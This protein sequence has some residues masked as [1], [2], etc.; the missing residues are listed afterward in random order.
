MPRHHLA[1]LLF[2]LAALNTPLG[3]T[4]AGRESVTLN[5]ANADI[6]TVVRA[7]GE[8]TGHN[9]L[10]DP[11]I[12]GTVNIISSQ[13]VSRALAYQILLSSLRLQGFSAVEG[14][15]VV[16]IVPESDAKLHARVATRGGQG[17]ERLIT[18]VFTLKNSN[19]AQLLPVIRPIVSPNNALSAFAQANALVVTDYADNLRRIESIVASLEGVADSQTA[20][21]PLLYASASELATTLGKLLQDAGSEGSR[22]IINADSRANV[23]LVRADLPGRLNQVRQLVQMLDQPSQAGANVRVVYLKNADAARVAQTL[24]ALL[25]S[26]AAPLAETRKSSLPSSPAA[27]GI[28]QGQVAGNQDAGS[29]NAAP[30]AADPAAAPDGSAAGNTPA[31]TLVQADTASNALILNVPDSMYRNLRNVI[32]LLDRRR[33]QVHVETLVMEVSAQRLQELGVRW[34]ALQTQPGSGSA[35][36]NTLALQLGSQG[37]GLTAGSGAGVLHVKGLGNVLDLTVLA[38]AL[39]TEAQGNILS[40]PTLM[41][42]D[43]EPARIEVGQEIAVQTGQYSNLGSGSN[44]ASPFTTYDRKTVGLKLAI[45]P[46]ISEGGSIRMKILQTASSIDP[47]SANSTLPTFNIRSVETSVTVEDG[48]IIAI[49]GLIQETVSNNQDKIPLLGDIPGLGWLFRHQVKA[50]NKTNLL[51]F[52]KP[53]IVRDDGGARAIAEERYRYILGDSY[54]RRTSPLALDARSA[55]EALPSGIKSLQGEGGAP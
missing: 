15:G 37:L 51:V 3:A 12:K 2:L 14:E 43:N 28:G 21:V 41:A 33:A 35:G 23:L 39:E 18:R 26:S 55:L 29:S 47:A 24:R 7:I 45:V 40:N 38:R 11:R 13:P 4:P 10:L 6:E 20:V 50:R 54:A 31:S 30:L 36:G 1:G 49:G 5:F 9:F 48:G 34:Q 17:G 25:S 8:M 19:A 27:S 53:T 52:L 42:T 16:K 32:D 46:Q 22:L 44:T